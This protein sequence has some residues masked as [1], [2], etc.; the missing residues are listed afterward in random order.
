M[1][2]LILIGVLQYYLNIALI[3]TD[4]QLVDTHQIPVLFLPNIKSLLKI[5]LTDEYEW[6]FCP[7]ATTYFLCPRAS[8]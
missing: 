3:F 6:R 5:M 8:V 1:Q 4:T 7:C 2:L